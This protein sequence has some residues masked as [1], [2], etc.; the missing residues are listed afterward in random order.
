MINQR[1]IIDN[2][3][4]HHCGE[5]TKRHKQA[6]DWKA[7]PMRLERFD[8]NLLLTLEALLDEKSV[9]RAA[10]RLNITQPAVSNALA[11]PGCSI[12]A[13]ESMAIFPMVRYSTMNR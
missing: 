12:A 11:L 3:G 2:Y 1:E 8:L 7:A 4:D 9:S 13:L 10:E 6:D 5:Y